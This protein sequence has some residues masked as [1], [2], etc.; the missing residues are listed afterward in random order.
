MIHPLHPVNEVMLPLPPVA[1]RSFS[2]KERKEMDALPPMLMRS[3]EQIVVIGKEREK[4]RKRGRD[5]KREMS[6]DTG[7]GK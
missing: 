5:G 1:A 2:F 4:I 3:R 7:V 6:K